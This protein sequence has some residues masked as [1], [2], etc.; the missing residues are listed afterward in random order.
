MDVLLQGAEHDKLVIVRKPF[1]GE[2]S[3]EFLEL[4]SVVKALQ[5]TSPRDVREGIKCLSKWYALWVLVHPQFKVSD[6]HEPFLLNFSY[7]RELEPE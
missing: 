3:G 1:L 7:S 5:L 6:C 2:V 4:D